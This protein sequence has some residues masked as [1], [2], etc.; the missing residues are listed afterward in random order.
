MFPSIFSELLNNFKEIVIP[1][2]LDIIIIAW[3]IFVPFMLFELFWNKWKYFIQQRFIS[4]QKYILL[5]IR[6][7]K[8]TVK[9]PAAMELV[10][11]SMYST[12]GEANFYQKYWLGSVR[13]WHSLEMVSIEGQVKFYIWSRKG[14]KKIIENALYSQYPDIEVYE[15]EDYTRSVDFNPK[16]DD[17]W[18]GEFVLTKPDPYPIKTYVDYGLDRDPKEEYKIDPITPGIEFL[19]SIGANQQ[20]WVQILFRAHKPEVVKKGFWFK[21]VDS[22]TEEAKSIIN[23]LTQRDAKTRFPLAD[24][25]TKLKITMTKG[26]EDVVGAIERALQKTQF[27]VGI[28]GIYIAKKENYDGT[29]VGGLT[30]MWKH[31]GTDHLNGFKPNGDKYSP[32]IKFPWQ[33]FRGIRKAGAIK[34]AITAYKLRAIFYSHGL[35]SRIFVLNSEELATIFHFPGQVSKTPTLPRISSKKGEPPP[36]LPI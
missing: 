3:P 27:D 1:R 15:A 17:A 30:G 25:D 23:E 21:T 26:E 8:E 22:L 35:F 20:V 34:S 10:L 31:F 24:E 7:P 9:S 32:S 16:T 4:S 29:N 13:P 36:N 33:D 2:V 18:A 28:R 11:L 12:L 14:F 19:G 6:V 5:E